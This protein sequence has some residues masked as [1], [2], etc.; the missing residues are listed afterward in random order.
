MRIRILPV[1]LSAFIAIA[2]D[3]STDTLGIYADAD[4]I[5]STATVVEV[6]TRSIV[7]DSVLSNSNSSY[8]GCMKDPETGKLI[9]AEFLAQF[10]TLE[11]YEFP[12]F[13]D[14]K[15]D[16]EGKVYADSVE[17]RLY[18]TQ[19]Y[20]AENNPLKL[21]VWELDSTNVIRE[22]ST[23]YSNADLTKYINRRRTAPLATKVFTAKDF[24]LT[25]DQL[26]SSTYMPN[27][28]I[29][30]PMDYG[31]EIIR[32]YY[33]H[34]E[35]FQNSY[36]FIRHVCPGFYF[37]LTD[38]S[39]TMVKMRVGTL[40][41]YFQYN[42]NGTYYT[43][44]SRFAATPEVL[45][46]THIENQNLKEF[47]ESNTDC[48]F[49]KTPAGI[50][51]EMTL[52]IEEIINGH[53]NDS[54]SQAQ[55]TLFRYNTTAS[56][57]EAFSAPQTLLMVR[58]DEMHSFFEQRKVNDGRTSFVASFNSSY[59]SYTFTNIGNLVSFCK[60]ARLNAQ[61]YGTALSENW[62][63]VVLIPVETNT[64]NSNNVI[65]V[66]HDMSLSSARLV[67]GSQ[68]KVSMQV[69]YSRFQ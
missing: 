64:D 2:C 51:T 15:K 35:Y 13:D 19:Y 22:D 23:Y 29:V 47:V 56:L 54:I 6:S 14:M 24:T 53:E 48:T 9:K 67:G 63:K 18:F 25:D 66:T 8:L 60:Q 44:L 62:N 50:F 52:P 41:V 27:I 26:S 7:A 21:E 42:E 37:K 59:N 33:E 20:G 3:N 34:K 17:I 49:L 57:D 68:D 16:T 36:N 65:S 10:S 46:S 58:K 28:R 43:G 5:N 55:I 32:K 38:G 12:P 40:N 45:Q 11:N 69:I 30:L 61:K 31:S 4:N 1:A 39:G